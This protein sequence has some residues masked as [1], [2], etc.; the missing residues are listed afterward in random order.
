M[1][2]NI[3]EVCLK[4]RCIS[5]QPQSQNDGMVILCNLSFHEHIY[6]Y[7]WKSFFH[8]T[9]QSFEMKALWIHK[10]ACV[11][12]FVCLSGFHDI[13]DITR[14]LMAKSK[15]SKDISCFLTSAFSLWTILP[16][17]FWCNYVVYDVDL[18][19]FMAFVVGLGM[20]IGK[21]FVFNR[22]TSHRTLMQLPGWWWFFDVE[23]CFNY[24][25]EGTSSWGMALSNPFDYNEQQ[26]EMEN[27]FESNQALFPRS[28]QIREKGIRTYLSHFANYDL[29][30][31]F[32]RQ[33]RT[34]HKQL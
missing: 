7:L 19:C 12:L 23:K 4:C 34:F 16:P 11:C 22:S 27:L 17:P 5:I 14:A 33:P 20:V 30:F 6:T 26:S 24:R 1:Q 3:L 15:N 13:S 25:H 10:S 31:S 28:A 21:Q 8:Q 32:N 2:R 9:L 29:F 18:H